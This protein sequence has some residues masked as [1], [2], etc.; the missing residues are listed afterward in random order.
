MIE[1][2]PQHL[3]LIVVLPCPRLRIRTAAMPQT[4]A[5]L[6]VSLERR[7]LSRLMPRP[8]LESTLKDHLEGSLKVQSIQMPGGI[9]ATPLIEPELCQT[10]QAMDLL[11]QDRTL[12]DHPKM[13]S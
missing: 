12:L 3:I 4:L 5:R 7:D 10:L 1:P 13:R 9:T 11:N 8:L 2:A 6:Q